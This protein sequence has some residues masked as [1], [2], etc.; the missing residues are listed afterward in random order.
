MALLH[1]LQSLSCE[2]NWLAQFQSTLSAKVKFFNKWEKWTVPNLVSLERWFLCCFFN[3]LISYFCNK[4]N[5]DHLAHFG[6]WVRICKIFICQLGNSVK[7]KCSYTLLKLH[8]YCNRIKNK[9][10]HIPLTLFFTLCVRNSRRMEKEKETF[11][12]W[13]GRGYIHVLLF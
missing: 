9:K 6:I 11:N 8:Y 10:L 2:S 3:S 5:I 7:S 13:Y 1:K 4:K 12:H